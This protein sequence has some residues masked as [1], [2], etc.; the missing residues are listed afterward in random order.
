F[1][2]GMRRNWMKDYT[3]RPRE[4]RGDQFPIRYLEPRVP[5]NLRAIGYNM[6]SEAVRRKAM[7]RARDTAEPA[8]TSRVILVQDKGLTDQPGFLAYV[9]IYS[10]LHTPSSVEER[11]KLIQGFA[12]SPI[13]AYE[14]FGSLFSEAS[15]SPDIGVEVY[16]GEG[17]AKENLLYRHEPAGFQGRPI[18]HTDTESLSLYGAGYRIRFFAPTYSWIVGSAEFLTWIPVVGLVISM[19]IFGALRAQLTMA[20]ESRAQ[21]LEANRRAERERLL[22]DTGRVLVSSLDSS[23]TLDEVAKLAVPDFADWCSVDVPGPDGDLRRLSVRHIDPEKIALANDLMR[24]YPP[25]KD[26][27]RGVYHVLRTGI[28]EWARVIPE[29]LIRENAK[30]PEHL[31]LLLDLGLK[32]YMCVPMSV[33]GETLGAI[34][35]VSSD[36]RRLYDEEDFRIAQ[37]IG[38]RAAI[39]LDNARLYEEAQ[40]EIAERARVED[41]IRELNASLEKI[42]EDRTKE[43]RA[44]NLELEAFCYSVSHDLRTPLRSVDG[45]SKALLEDYGE[46]LPPEAHGYLERV[47]KANQ[48]M[49]E[50]ITALLTLSR[51]TRAE[52]VRENVNL[53]EIAES[54]AQEAS[55]D[56]PKEDLQIIVQ[57]DMIARADARMVHIVFDNLISNALKFSMRSQPQVVEVGRRAGVFF[58]RDNGVG[59]NPHYRA[60]LFAPFERLHNPKE[61]PGT[62][63]G[64]ATVQRVVHKH[65]GEIWAESQEGEGATFYFTLS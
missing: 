45:F 40:R 20:E 34:S 25:D 50:L 52:I 9:P 59:F 24:R 54:V 10:S 56:L 47:R 46:Q 2:A 14:F 5:A 4:Y 18:H 62:G 3:V 64:L 31:E 11:R 21:A 26:A 58:V 19:L 1:E 42:V 63:V 36:P 61:F 30:D 44:T 53:S 23:K 15:R 6:Y 41:Q 37:E 16:S 55:R 12:Y 43:L 48:R 35:F 49:D 32:S 33:R 22:S 39:A 27:P 29:N 7:A 65:G 60:K 13:R 8:L 57:P 51:I 38:T 28:A 17:Y